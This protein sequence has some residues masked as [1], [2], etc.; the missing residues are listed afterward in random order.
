M[1]RA[2]FQLVSV[3]AGVPV[4]CVLVYAWNAH[5]CT[6][7]SL[8]RTFV[9]ICVCMSACM[10]AC[11]QVSHADAVLVGAKGVFVNK[12]A[13]QLAKAFPSCKALPNISMSFF[14]LMIV[15]SRCDDIGFVFRLFVYHEFFIFSP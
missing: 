9:G 4:V 15:L 10:Y 5:V 12:A 3:A 1:R 11:T 13:S 14:K 6:I 2:C 7:L 8:M